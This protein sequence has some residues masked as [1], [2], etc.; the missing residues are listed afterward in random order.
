MV[1]TGASTAGVRCTHHVFSTMS[2]RAAMYAAVPAVVLG[3][4]FAPAAFAHGFGAFGMR[5][6]E[7]AAQLQARVFQ[8]HAAA[9]GLSV[10]VLKE[11]WADGKSIREIAVA[12]G[13][14]DAQVQ[15]RLLAAHK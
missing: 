11:G 1:D 7:E 3:L 6:P 4:A 13:L 5:N 14:T 12:H 8:Q 10:D 15:E 2:K 9:L